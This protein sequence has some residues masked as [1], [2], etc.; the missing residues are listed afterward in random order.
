MGARRSLE[1]DQSGQA[2]PHRGLQD[3]TPDA[4]QTAID[5]SPEFLSKPG[6]KPPV[7]FILESTARFPDPAWRVMWGEVG[8][9][10][11]N[12]VFV[13]ATTGKFLEREQ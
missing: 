8:S 11:L 7:N 3:D 5:K 9:T 13:D 1:S 4:L 12:S 10:A 2:I 6:A